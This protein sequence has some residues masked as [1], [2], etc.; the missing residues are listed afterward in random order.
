MGNS[1]SNEKER[2][3]QL[4]PEQQ[5]RLASMYGSSGLNSYEHPQVGY[6]VHRDMGQYAYEE[7]KQ[8]EAAQK[9]GAA[10]TSTV[11]ASSN[12]AYILPNTLKIEN[13][14]DYANCKV[15]KFDFKINV[16]ATVVVTLACQPHK[17]D[18]SNPFEYETMSTPDLAS[19]SYFCDPDVNGKQNTISFVFNPYDFNGYEMDKYSEKF[20]P[21][22]I[23]IYA[24]YPHGT[25][26]QNEN[27]IYC[28]FGFGMN[29]IKIER[30]VIRKD[31]RSFEMKTVYGMAGDSDGSNVCLVCLEN[32]KNVILK[33]CSHMCIC[34][35]CAEPMLRTGQ[36]CP[37]CRAKIEEIEKLD[38]VEEAQ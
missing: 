32:P 26:K 16:K 33:P 2:L 21:C 27:F 4:T 25:K 34:S 24:H 18:H 14:P 19:K 22:L 20:Y 29:T 7:I 38:I 5:Q 11:A 23:H 37:V 12:D 17:P 1:D 13:S 36:K 28:S 3:P 8:A 35:V 6:I 15:V 10:K 31:G 9:L 30:N